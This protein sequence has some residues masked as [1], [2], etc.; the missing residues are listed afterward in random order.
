MGIESVTEAKRTWESKK[1]DLLKNINMTLEEG[2][3]IDPEVLEIMREMLETVKV[4]V[5]M[6]DYFDKGV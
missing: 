4:K 5:S 2:R 6:Q 1:S 3:C